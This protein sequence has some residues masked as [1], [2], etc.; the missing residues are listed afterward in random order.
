MVSAGENEKTEKDDRGIEKKI[1]VKDNGHPRDIEIHRTWVTSH[2]LW[3]LVSVG[4]CAPRAPR[5]PFD[6]SWM[7]ILAELNRGLVRQLSSRMLVLEGAGKARSQ[8]GFDL[9]HALATPSRASV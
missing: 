2:G 8:H 4:I 1:G 7:L 6:Q 3:S 9:R 5:R